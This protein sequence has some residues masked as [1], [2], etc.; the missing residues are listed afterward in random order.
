MEEIKKI[1]N[2]HKTFCVVSHYNPDADAYGSTL[3]LGLAIESTGK[4]VHFLNQDGMIAKFNFLPSASKII[5]TPPAEVDCIFILDCGDEKRTGDNL[6][7]PKAKLKVNID[8]HISNNKFGDLALVDTK[9]SSTC[10]LVFSVIE[11]LISPDVA[12]NLLAGI[13][14]DTGSLRYGNTSKKTLLIVSK[15]LEAGADLTLISKKLFGAH[16]FSSV[17]LQ[18]M[19]LSAMRIEN[20]V[21]WVVVTKDMLE[22]SKATSEDADG[23]AEKGRD[24]E[25]VKIAASVRFSPQENLWR[26]S[27]RTHDPEI[28]L[29]SVASEFGGGGH[30]AAA[31]FRWR[32]SY[33]ELENKLL[34]KLKTL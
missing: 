14:A 10:E 12:T 16:T 11:E 25:G 13:Y 34:S 31:A 4:I 28:D 22:A 20:A 3:A 32:K 30:K 15:L 9:A 21:A 33:E 26:I 2:D 18:S 27:L 6:V 7:L 29:S 8:H 5:S 23:L 1:I 17:K 24:I 19:A